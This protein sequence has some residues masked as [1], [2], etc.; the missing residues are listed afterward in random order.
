MLSINKDDFCFLLDQPGIILVSQHSYYNHNTTDR[1][2]SNSAKPLKVCG[3]KE[4]EAK[5]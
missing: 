5:L 1:L 2:P 4:K 3:F